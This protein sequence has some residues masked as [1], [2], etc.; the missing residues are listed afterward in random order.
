[1]HRVDETSRALRL[2]VSGDPEFDTA[3]S[4]V[5][6]P[7]LTIGV[8]LDAVTPNIEPD[9]RVE[10]RVLANKKMHEFVVEGGTVFRS[11]EVALGEPPVANGFRNAADELANTCFAL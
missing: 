1:M 9:G 7:I 2:L 6:V 10:G 4:G 11:A 8:G 5:P 3:E